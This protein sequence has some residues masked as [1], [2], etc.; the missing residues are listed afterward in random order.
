[1]SPALISADDVREARKRRETRLVVPDG[2][3]VTPLARDEA[4]RHGIE[5]VEGAP[6]SAATIRTSRPA[7]PAGPSGS[8]STAPTP[9]VPTCD[10]PGDPLD[11]I[12]ARVLARVPDADPAQVREIARRVLE[13]RER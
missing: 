7:S 11:R 9:H 6:D 8:G 13:S 10:D 2:A 1:M 3:I 12:V 4:A 5:L